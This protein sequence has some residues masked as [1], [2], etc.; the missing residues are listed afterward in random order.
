M[1]EV[2]QC[3]NSRYVLSDLENLYDLSASI[4][5]T[6]CFVNDRTKLQQQNNDAHL[7]INLDQEQFSLGLPVIGLPSEDVFDQQERFYLEDYDQ[8]KVF[9]TAI[10]GFSFFRDE[11]D[12]LFE[13]I[14]EK[15]V[16]VFEAE[17]GRPQVVRLII[18]NWPEQL[19]NMKENQ[20]LVDFFLD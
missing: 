17:G 11:A 18:K 15:I 6:A 8:F 20:L 16:S 2:I 10:E 13:L 12:S 5:Q 3:E 19:R 14:E 1:G 7:F 9:R 4:H